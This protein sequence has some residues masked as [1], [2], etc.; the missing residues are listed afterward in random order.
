MTTSTIW[1]G[2]GLVGQA[3]FFMR[4]LVQWIASEFK[5][6]SVL[7][8]AFWYFSIL[9]GIT[10]LTYAVHQHDIVFIIGQGTGLLIYARN[11][12]LSRRPAQIETAEP[13]A[14]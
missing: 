4:F 11:I 3:L 14:G 10:L 12:M 13:S 6:R 8:Q 5:R 1:L 9:G 2:I 7:P